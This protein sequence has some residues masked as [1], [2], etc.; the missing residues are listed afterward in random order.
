MFLTTAVATDHL[1]Q[2]RPLRSGDSDPNA[3]MVEHTYR[4]IAINCVT[5]KTVWDTALYKGIPKIQRHSKASHANP[6]V[7]TDW[8][9]P[10]F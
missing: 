9:G 2:G 8:T 4:T 5:G 3:D 1:R 7:A 6:T 10:H